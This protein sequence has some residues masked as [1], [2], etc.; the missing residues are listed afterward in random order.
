MLVS[1]NPIHPLDPYINLH[2]SC[3]QPLKPRHLE[4]EIFTPLNED[5]NESLF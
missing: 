3:L 4:P 2:N 5:R 1:G